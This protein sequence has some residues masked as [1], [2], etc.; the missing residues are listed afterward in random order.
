[1]RREIVARGLKPLIDFR[2]V[3]EAEHRDAFGALGGTRTPAL[4]DGVRLH[5]GYEAVLVALRAIMP[6]QGGGA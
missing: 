2:N 5:E 1:V 3:V 4:W 6:P